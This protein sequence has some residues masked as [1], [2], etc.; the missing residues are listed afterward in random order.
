MKMRH[1]LTH[2]EFKRGLR[3][4]LPIILGAVPFALILGAQA[5]QKGM[6]A[7]ETVM[8]MGLNF[9]GGSEFAAVNLWTS[10]LPVLLIIATTA[11]INSRHILMGAAMA[12]LL[13]HL[14]LRKVLPAL[15]MMTDES[16][17]MG[18]ADSQKHAQKQPA[19]LNY[20]YYMGTALSL[21]LTWV[22]CGSLG[23]SLAPMLGNVERF[24]FGMALPAVFLV[25]LR[26]MWRGWFAARPWLVSLLAAACT[27]L[28]APNTGWYVVVGSLAGLVYAYFASDKGAA[29]D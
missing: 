19:R 5:G 20:E 6:S 10:P 13:R 18:I 17:A 8:M 16:W 9:A 4:S 29:H 23:A 7:L 3:E 26:G 1:F 24:G 21:Y 11:M 28:A 2:A 25:L 27:Y 22:G 15:F 14:P 12:P